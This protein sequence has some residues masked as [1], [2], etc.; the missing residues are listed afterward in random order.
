M[1]S[2]LDSAPQSQVKNVTERQQTDIEL[3]MLTYP[4]VTSHDVRTAYDMFTE[5]HSVYILVRVNADYQ[6]EY[7]IRSTF[8]TGL[9]ASVKAMAVRRYMD[10]FRGGQS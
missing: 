4:H 2:I 5:R 8:K 10:A 3:L 1:N 9:A 7:R 6:F